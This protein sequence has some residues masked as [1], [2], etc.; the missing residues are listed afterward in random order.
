[1][2]QEFLLQCFHESSGPRETRGT[3]RDSWSWVSPAPR[4]INACDAVTG[5]A[6]AVPRPR[7][8][9]TD[10]TWDGPGRGRLSHRHQM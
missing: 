9:T 2:D 3:L 7:P 10:D 5:D 6:P 1:M 8:L 4:H